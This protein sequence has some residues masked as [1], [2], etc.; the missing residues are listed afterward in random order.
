MTE[1]LTGF[2]GFSELFG[3]RVREAAAPQHR[4][5]FLCKPQK[6]DGRFAQTTW[7]NASTRQ[8]A[9]SAESGL[10]FRHGCLTGALLRTPAVAVVVAPTV[11][12]AAPDLHGQPAPVE[13][14]AAVV[15]AAPD[16][17]RAVQARFAEPA[18]HA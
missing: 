7:F 13:V 4:E 14:A 18:Q 9:R 15:V 6:D 11:V 8:S 12:C 10:N 1:G 16:G 3:T 5:C 17:I 2:G